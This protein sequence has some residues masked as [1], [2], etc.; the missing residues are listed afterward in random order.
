[1]NKFVIK[2]AAFYWPNK[3][4]VCSGPP[5]AHATARCSILS[6]VSYYVIYAQ[7]KHRVFAVDYPVCTRHR[8][9]ADTTGILSKKSLFNLGISVIWAFV[10]FMLSLKYGFLAYDC[11]M[12]G[13]FFDGLEEL[14]IL[15]VIVGIGPLIFF[16]IRFFT[17]VKIHSVTDRGITLS[18]TNNDYARDFE[19]LNK[20]I[21]VKKLKWWQ[22]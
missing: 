20:Q 17:P 15:L 21:V 1:M 6:D 4:A 9:I 12:K 2:N 19:R 5:D 8:G 16:I 14:F 13:N 11:F 10:A 7:T 18:I 3:C 22:E